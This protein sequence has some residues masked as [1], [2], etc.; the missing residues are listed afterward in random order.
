MKALVAAAALALALSGCSGDKTSVTMGDVAR[1]CEQHFQKVLKGWDV[2]L[3]EPYV[4]E[5]NELAEVGG[6]ARM[7]GERDREV[8]CDVSLF[9]NGKVIS[10]MH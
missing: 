10:S 3:R 7:A 1:L 4:V 6:T 9:D 8:T 2:Q 5:E